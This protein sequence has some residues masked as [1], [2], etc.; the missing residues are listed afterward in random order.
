MAIT[1]IKPIRGTISKAL[2]YIENPDKTDEKLL[3]SSFGCSI[4]TAAKEFEW[5]RR[6]AE[7]QGMNPTKIIARHMIQSFAVGE[8]SPELA[9]EIGQ[10]FADEVLQGKYE[11]VCEFS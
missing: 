5:T 3:V 7:Q 4:E 11:Y 8:V 10:Q 6:I 1:K 9:H 2:A